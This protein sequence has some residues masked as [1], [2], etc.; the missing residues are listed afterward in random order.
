[1]FLIAV[2]VSAD[3]EI[4]NTV[5][6]LMSEN[7]HLYG[8]EAVIRIEYRFKYFATDGVTVKTRLSQ[9]ALNFQLDITNATRVS[10]SGNQFSGGSTINP[11]FG[12]PVPKLLNGSPNPAWETATP[13]ADFLLQKLKQGKLD[14][15]AFME[16]VKIPALDAA[17]A[18]VL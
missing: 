14:F 2:T 11:L 7:V 3:S 18:F 8:S 1:M 9:N 10:S 5:R 17:G 4:P 12:V 16:G 15:I 6:K 13:E